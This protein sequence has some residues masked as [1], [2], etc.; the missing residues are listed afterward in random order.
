M[1]NG[2]IVGM[3]Q[4]VNLKW[5]MLWKI[6]IQGLNFISIFEKVST[7]ISCHLDSS[8][9]AQ[10]EQVKNNYMI[11]DNRTVSTLFDSTISDFQPA[12]CISQDF[13]V[14]FGQRDTIFWSEEG[15]TSQEPSQMRVMGGLQGMVDDLIILKTMNDQFLQPHVD[16]FAMDNWGDVN[17][18]PVNHPEANMFWFSFDP[19]GQSDHVV[20]E[21]SPGP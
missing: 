18:G 11:F 10:W 13:R 16:L 21:A 1:S 2:V 3:F 5:I 6:C 8:L 9:L 17:A 15:M 7:T 19:S 14:G 20:E 4:S 12:Q